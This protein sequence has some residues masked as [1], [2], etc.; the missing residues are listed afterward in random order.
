MTHLWLLVL[1]L[2]DFVLL[3]GCVLYAQN[4]FPCLL[5]CS[6]L[7]IYQLFSFLLPKASGMLCI[8]QTFKKCYE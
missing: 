1:C 2:W 5:N 7:N 3:S 8:Q 4:V 6:L